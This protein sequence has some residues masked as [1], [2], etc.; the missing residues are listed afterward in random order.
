[1]SSSVLGGV[2][3]TAAPAGCACSGDVHVGWASGWVDGGGCGGGDA[4]AAA[5][6][7]GQLQI[8]MA[9]KVIRGKKT[10]DVV[11]IVALARVQGLFTGPR[12]DPSTTS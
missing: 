3:L 7:A 6:G 2:Q 5:V 11:A 10:T 1:M 12:I 4:P 9:S 8:A